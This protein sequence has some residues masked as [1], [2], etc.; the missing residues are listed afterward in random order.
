[1]EALAN[2]SAYVNAVRNSDWQN[3]RY[4]G[5]AAIRRIAAT[6]TDMRFLKLYHDNAEFRNG[7]RNDV[8][9]A[10]YKEVSERPAVL[11]PREPASSAYG[12]GDFVWLDGREF[13]ITDLQRGYVE[14]LPPEL[15]YPIYR[16][17]HRADFE[18]MLRRDERNRHITDH[19]VQEILPSEVPATSDETV[20]SEEPVP[21]DKAKS[22]VYIP[23]DGEWQSFP[24]VAAAEVAALEEF[25]KETRRVARNFRIT[26]DHLGEGGAKAKCR[27]NIEAIRLLKYLEDNGFQASPEQQEVLSRYVGWGGIPKVFDESKT[28]WSNE[29]AELKALLTPE[30]YEAARGSTLNAHYTSPA[31]IRAIYEAVGSMGFEGGRILEPSMGVGNFFGLLP[32]SMQGSQLYGVELDSITGRIAKQLYPE[33]NITVAGFE[34]TNRPG[35]YDLAVG[36]VPFGQYQVHDPEYDRLGFSI[37]NYFAA[38]ML[39]QVR[40]GGIVA[41]VTSRYTLDAKDESVRRYLAER[42]ELLGAIRLPN[43]AFRANAG[44]D[45]V[46]DIIFLQRR[47]QPL[48]E[49][50]DWVHVGTTPEGFTV[51]RYFI[52]HPDMV[53]GTPTAESTQYGRQDYTVAP[54]EGADLSEQLHEA[55]QKIHCEY[56]ERE[57]AEAER[58]DVLPADPDVRNYSFTLVD[59]EVYYRESG[60]MVRQ[61]VSAAMTERI[62][63]LMELRDCTRRLIQLQTE[64]A[65]DTEIAAEQQRLNQLYDA[66]PPSTA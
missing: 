40:P 54:I 15:P 29:Y 10:A 51:N 37:H 1:M 33:A 55:V 2:D 65:G 12:V 48:T 43:N 45:V 7:L 61:D 59:G 60:I 14:L 64:D 24:S 18:R 6:S 36:N 26:D 19:L 44:T 56:T 42:G 16:T 39:D 20:P 11:Q 66:Y 58:S 27:A 22:A 31:V 8:L 5:F 50:P 3:A 28:E 47:E 17:E 57:I 46:S 30:E 13:K 21:S 4:E 25:R 49:L 63:G 41:F 34:T 62:K 23:V 35:F 38:K 9:A 32:E 52:D 53:L